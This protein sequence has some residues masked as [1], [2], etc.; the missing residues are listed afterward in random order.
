MYS[1]IGGLSLER[2]SKI[3]GK[4]AIMDNTPTM[5]GASILIM[6]GPWKMNHEIALTI[7]TT[8]PKKINKLKL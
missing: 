8:N 1:R 3:P 2:A 6:V 7:V 5:N 4:N